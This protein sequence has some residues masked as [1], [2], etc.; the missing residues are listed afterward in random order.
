MAARQLHDDW[1][2][3]QISA[4]GNA[5]APSEPARPDRPALHPPRAMP[6]RRTGSVKGRIALVH[7][8]AHIECNAIDLAFDIIARF[9][10]PALPHSFHDDWLCIGAEEA[11]HFLRLE[12]RLAVLGAAYGDLP[13]HGG[14]WQAAAATADDL[15]ARL[16]VV[17]LVLEARGLDITPALIEQLDRAGDHETA[18]CLAVILEDE[19]GHVAAGRYWFEWLARH[20][21]L[22]PIP[23]WQALVARHIPAALKPPF[24]E[25]ARNRAGFARA[26]YDP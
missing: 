9:A 20:R 23:A 21:G 12:S 19:I 6:R 18:S 25:N 5:G 22:A 16:A 26:Y 13:A 10:E 15:L 4:L 8:L 24:N 3:G 2:K 14:L 7:A 11:G 1:V 17:P